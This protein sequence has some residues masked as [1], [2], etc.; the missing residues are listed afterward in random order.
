MQAAPR[1]S[2]FAAMAQQLGMSLR[3]QRLLWLG[4]GVVALG[5]FLSNGLDRWGNGLIAKSFHRDL[6]QEMVQPSVSLSRAQLTAL[7][8]VPERSPKATIRQQ[9]PEPYCTL[10]DLEIRA[11][12]TAQREAYPLA[13]DPDTWLVMLYEGDEYAGYAF[14]FK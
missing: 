13:F 2:L 9:A 10:S 5:L 4:G 1:P 8:A 6:C 14:R 11:G 7:I 3:P 12:V